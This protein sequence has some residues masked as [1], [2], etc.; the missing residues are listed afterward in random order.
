MPTT[1]YAD[2]AIG[3][4]VEI[5]LAGKGTGVK[6]ADGDPIFWKD[7]GSA[8]SSGGGSRTYPALITGK[9]GAFYTADKYENGLG[10]ATT[11]E[12]T[13][14]CV[15]LSMADTLPNGTPVVVNLSAI[16]VTGGG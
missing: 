1:T 5:E 8:V 16:A 14:E 10:N 15:G 7:K 3:D 2:Y 12:V 9:S 4:I 13:L 11:G 6:D